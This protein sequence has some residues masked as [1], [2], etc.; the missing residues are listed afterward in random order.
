MIVHP[1]P[2]FQLGRHRHCHGQECPS[3]D[4][5]TLLLASRA[6]DGLQLDP[7]ERWSSRSA[8]APGLAGQR[9]HPRI[10]GRRGSHPH[11]EGRVRTTQTSPGGQGRRDHLC[12]RKLG[13]Q[14]KCPLKSKFPNPSFTHICLIHL[15]LERPARLPREPNP[16]I[17]D[18]V[19]R[20][21]LGIQGGLV[22]GRDGQGVRRCHRLVRPGRRGLPLELEGLGHQVQSRLLCVCRRLQ[23]LGE[24]FRSFSAHIAAAE[25]TY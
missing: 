20:G 4:R 24:R 1:Q 7:D 14:S 15:G 21:H 22:S 25:S 23:E 16:P 9:T 12:G 11:H 3:L 17:G 6:G 18:Q 8:V 13:G 10:Q 2:C 5:R 19:Y